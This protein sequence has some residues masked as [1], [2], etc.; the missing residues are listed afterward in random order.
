MRSRG[1]EGPCEER[2]E[3]CTER[4]AL[5]DLRGSGARA[6]ASVYLWGLGR[7]GG[8]KDQLAERAQLRGCAGWRFGALAARFCA[9][10]VREREAECVNRRGQ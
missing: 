4:V 10:R 7:S 8:M 6:L 5:G 3:Q 1:N 2:G 9:G